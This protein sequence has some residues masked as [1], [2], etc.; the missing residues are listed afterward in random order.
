[1]PRVSSTFEAVMFCTNTELAGGHQY[2]TGVDL[3]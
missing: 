2:Q 1:V 3:I